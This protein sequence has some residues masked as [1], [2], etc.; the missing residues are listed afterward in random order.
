ME[1]H[2]SQLQQYLIQSSTFLYSNI[3][4]LYSVK[5]QEVSVG[6]PNFTI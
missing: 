1:V 3:K 4:Y 2:E 6:Q 5:C